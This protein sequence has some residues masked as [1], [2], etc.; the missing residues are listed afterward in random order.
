MAFI[1]ST[2]YNNWLLSEEAVN[3]S[4]N[5]A[6][7]KYCTLLKGTTI[8]PLTLFEEDLLLV[9]YNMVKQHQYYYLLKPSL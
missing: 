8:T 2:H 6:Y 3:T 7:E 1:D 5:K 9:Y 4:K